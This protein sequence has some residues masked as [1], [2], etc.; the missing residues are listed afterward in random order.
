MVR[1]IFGVGIG[2]LLS[3]FAFAQNS[4]IDSLI[5]ALE[6][7]KSNTDRADIAHA[8]AAASWDYDFE[9]AYKY[10]QQCMEWSEKEGYIEGQVQAL[11]DFGLYH[12]FVGDYRNASV[13]YK[14]ALQV[15]GDKNFGDYP[16]YTLT[17]LGNLLRVQ[18]E[19]DSARFYY[20]K[21]LQ[22]LKNQKEIWRYP[23]FIIILDYC[24]TTYRVL[25]MH[26][27]IYVSHSSYD[28]G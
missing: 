17:R 9:Q 18:A 11:T 10:A 6:E 1:K 20:E 8:L 19:F 16:A 13:N 23:P 26:F 3:A 5:S 28:L 14:K 7:A 27:L 4:S 25:M 21:S 22:A 15:C 2:V 12:Y 24:Q